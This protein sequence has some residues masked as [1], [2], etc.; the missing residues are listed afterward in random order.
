MSKEDYE[1]KKRKNRDRDDNGDDG[2]DEGGGILDTILG[3]IGRLF[4]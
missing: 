2:D 3:F 4:G 1:N